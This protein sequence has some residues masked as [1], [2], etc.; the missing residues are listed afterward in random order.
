MLSAHPTETA[1]T[2]ETTETTKQWAP[3]SAA[4]RMWL[5]PSHL[6]LPP[7]TTIQSETTPVPTNFPNALQQRPSTEQ[8][9]GAQ[10]QLPRWQSKHRV[11][12]GGNHGNRAGST[13]SSR[14][15]CMQFDFSNDHGRHQKDGFGGAASPNV[16]VYTGIAVHQ[17]RPAHRATYRCTVSDPETTEKPRSARTTLVAA[18]HSRNMPVVVAVRILSAQQVLGRLA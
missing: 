5:T 14:R 8:Q 10:F 17:Q 11:G 1:E 18:N 3:A 6:K 15:L 4:L 2:A 16:H 13:P 12:F 7:V 9:L